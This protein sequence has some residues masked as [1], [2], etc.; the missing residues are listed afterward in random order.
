MSGLRS[1]SGVIPL[2]S[3]RGAGRAGRGEAALWPVSAKTSLSQ[4]RSSALRRTATSSATASRASRGLH[5]A[6]CQPSVLLQR[7]SC[8]GPAQLAT[9]HSPVGV[10]AGVP[11]AAHASLTLERPR[12]CLSSLGEGG[13]RCDRGSFPWGL[14]GSW[15]APDCWTSQSRRTLQALQPA[16][17]G[18]Y[19][20]LQ[21]TSTSCSFVS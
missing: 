4:P 2:G 10:A 7:P 1:C 21:H 16:R 9:F 19:R 13:T 14:G 12:R 17:A 11:G 20:T 8:S 15:P 6:E 5:G 3:G 18:P